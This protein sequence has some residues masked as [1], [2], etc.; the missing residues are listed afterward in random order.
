MDYFINFIKFLD[1]NGLVNQGLLAKWNNLG[2]GLAQRRP[3]FELGNITMENMPV[4]QLKG[5][6]FGIL[7]PCRLRSRIVLLAISIGELER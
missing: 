2:L 4:K 6:C 3:L 5:F 1:P 7:Q